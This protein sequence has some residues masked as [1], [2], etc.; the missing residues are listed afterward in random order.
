MSFSPPCSH[1]EPWNQIL[2]LPSSF[3]PFPAEN[4]CSFVEDEATFGKVQLRKIT[5]RLVHS[6]L[7][8]GDI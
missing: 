3:P 4:L 2:V 8:Q 5:E 6:L 7:L 1:P